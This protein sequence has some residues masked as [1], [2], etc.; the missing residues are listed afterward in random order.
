MTVRTDAQGRIYL[1]SELR[2]R[3]GEKFHVIEYEDR[4]ELVPIDEDPLAAVRDELDDALDGLSHEE[5]RSRARDRA[6]RAAK[7]DL[8]RPGGRDGGA[9]T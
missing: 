5:L 9:D 3:Y 2:E 7:S 8:E 1:T 4:L 6:S